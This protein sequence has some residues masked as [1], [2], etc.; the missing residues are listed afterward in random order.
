[1]RLAAQRLTHAAFLLVLARPAAFWV[2][3][4]YRSRRARWLMDA[5]RLDEADRLI[6]RLRWGAERYR[7][8]AG[9]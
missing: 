1:M 4:S 2:G 5:G 3:F 9:R 6:A 7:R 8:R